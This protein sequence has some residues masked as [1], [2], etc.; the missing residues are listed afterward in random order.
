MLKPLGMSK[1]VIVGPDTELEKTIK[2]LH[3]MKIVHI[4]DHKKNEVDI[5]EPLEIANKMSEILVK[6]RS[7][8]S[9]LKIKEELNTKK[10]EELRKHKL[11]VAKH[12]KE[13]RRIEEEINNTLEKLKTIENN[14]K[15]KKELIKKLEL[16]KPLDLAIESYSG[17]NSISNFT[18]HINKIDGFLDELEKITT[19]YHLKK[20]EIKK[21]NLIALFVE[22]N[23][24]KEVNELLNKYNFVS[25]EDF[26]IAE[27]KGDVNKHLLKTNR[28][29]SS[30]KRQKNRLNKQLQKMKKENSETLL[31][32]EKLLEEEL[33]KAEAPLRFAKTKNS[34][35]INCW[36]PT[37][38]VKKATKILERTTKKRIFI[39]TR[40][41]EEKD[42]IPVKLDNPELVKPFEFFMDLYT[43]PKYREIDPTFF[44][45][46]TFP[47]LF[48]FMLGDMGYGL[49]V[50][51]IAWLLK[52]AIPKVRRF[53]DVM[54][55][56]SLATIFFGALF[57]EFF[58][59]EV[60]FGYELPHIL[61]RAHQINTLLYVAVG[62]GVI[63]INWGLLN[64]FYNILKHHGL[65]K[66][67]CEKLSWI[68]LEAGVAL[69]ALYYLKILQISPYN[70]YAIILLAI[71]LLYLGEGIKGLVELPSLFS[72]IISYAR[73]MAIGLASVELAIVINE[74]AA[75]FISSGTITGVISAVLLMVIGHTINIGVG[76]L[77]SFLQSLRLHYVEYFSKF[78][79]GGAIRYKPFGVTS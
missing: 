18:G 11:A 35:I 49:V 61:S 19:R 29:L 13:T 17:Y 40:E 60:L 65:F 32:N 1:I 78:F 76:I 46:L 37:K 31:L 52:K 72:N 66:A 47:L 10:L 23:K 69:V 57:G 16:L 64:G 20:H 24:T 54:I 43:L 26:I 56:A 6:T 74:F 27:L 4:V 5:G 33:E 55:F 39:Q 59:F 73:L 67:V 70:G 7:I 48:G 8:I 44:V 30:L 36:L 2:C 77:G 71:V 53:F 62:V 3:K 34:F 79:E 42:K 38:K 15:N 22:K 21:K 75:V 12:E 9:Q 45:F 41:I 58:G 68:I 51:V 28:E 14:I 50:L 25:L 63:H